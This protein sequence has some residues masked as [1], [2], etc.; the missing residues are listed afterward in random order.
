MAVNKGRLWV[1]RH[2]SI[3]L[4][5]SGIEG[6]GENPTIAAWVFL[7]PK[8]DPD[9]VQPVAFCLHGGG[10]DKRYY[11]IEATGHDTYSMC[12]YFADRGIIA[13]TVDCLGTADSSAADTADRV[14]SQTLAKAHA[15]AAKVVAD[16][17]RSGTL[18]PGIPA[19]PRITYAGIGHSLG[20]MLLTVQQ[21]LHRSFDRVAILGWSNIGLALA[22]EALRPVFDATGTYAY[23]SPALRKA[24]HLADVPADLLQC[25]AETEV[26]PVSL[27]LAV[28][29]ADRP[30]TRKLAEV[31][32]VP[33][34]VGVGE[35]DTSPSPGQEAA[36]YTAA[37][38]ITFFRLSG[39]AHC[40]N[41]AATR[42]A[43]W[44]RLLRWIVD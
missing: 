23:S 27:T 3:A 39:S 43:L 30:A 7:P 1:S 33:V 25:P 35:Y 5:V 36:C 18:D 42:T 14:T 26:R 24:F 34:F 29:A 20:G 21:A 38:D 12:R 11:H 4:P 10:Y 19:L 44:D 6:F 22:P 41:F 9:A 17:L 2:L 8:R 15:I 32:D 37:E 40:H 31:I 28:E 13:I 16:R